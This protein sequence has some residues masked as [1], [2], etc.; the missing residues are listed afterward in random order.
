MDDDVF[1]PLGYCFVV[2][3]NQADLKIWK[4]NTKTDIAQASALWWTP[5]GGLAY[6]E[7]LWILTMFLLP[8]CQNNP[9][10]AK[11]LGNIQKTA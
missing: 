11:D 10:I 6:M 3:V 5:G 8:H 1:L 7:L 9:L 2:D 4:K